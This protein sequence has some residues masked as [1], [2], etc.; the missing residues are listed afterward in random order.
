M[1]RALLLFA[2]AVSCVPASAQSTFRWEQGNAYSDIHTYNGY[3]YKSIGFQNLVV[4]VADTSALR[5][6][7]RRFG[8]F[9]LVVVNE[10]KERRIELDPDRISCTCG[11]GKV[12]SVLPPRKVPV[13]NRQIFAG[14][15]VFPGDNY[16]GIVLFDGACRAGEPQVV[17]IRFPSVMLEY[18]F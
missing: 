15:T 12:L 9:L 18:P 13:P 16:R 4:Q 6:G 17:S 10:D 14:N 5:Y 1:K 11:G 2:V 8:A 3:R 7:L